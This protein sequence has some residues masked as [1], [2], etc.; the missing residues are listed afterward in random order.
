MLRFLDP[1]SLAVMVV[2]FVLF[3][4]ALFVGGFTHNLF[5]EAGVFLVSVKLIV[6]AYKNSVTMEELRRKLEEIHSAVL[7]LEERRDT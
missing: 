6:G 2:T 3:V 5:L 4:V 1:A 7:R